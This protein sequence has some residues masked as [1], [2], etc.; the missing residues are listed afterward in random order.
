[1]VTSCIHG[2]HI[3]MEN[4]SMHNNGY[5]GDESAILKN[6]G[7][8]NQQNVVKFEVQSPTG[9]NLKEKC[10]DFLSILV[11]NFGSESERV[12]WENERRKMELK[13]GRNWEIKGINCWL[14]I[15]DL[16]HNFSSVKRG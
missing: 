15:V 14:K 16:M 10:G 6:H 5:F 2:H 3:G 12:G 11:L 4:N 8:I 7:D 13:E 1:M 9:Q